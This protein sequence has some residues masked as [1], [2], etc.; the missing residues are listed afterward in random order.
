[1]RKKDNLRKL[2]NLNYVDLTNQTYHI[3]EFDFPNIKCPNG[4]SPDYLALY[5]EKNNYNKTKKT[6]VCFYQ[7]DNKFDGIKGLF[8]AIYYKDKKLLNE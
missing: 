8:N 1:M 4:V 7:Y 6:Y 3:G 5:S 2:L